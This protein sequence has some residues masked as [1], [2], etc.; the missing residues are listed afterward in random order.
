MASSWIIVNE[1]G[2]RKAVDLRTRTRK[3]VTAAVNRAKKSGRNVIAAYL[4]KPC[5][6]A[7]CPKVCILRPSAAYE[8]ECLPPRV[9]HS[10]G[11][12]RC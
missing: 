10:T 5:A 11:N 1:D 6:I 3:G 12:W 7:L 9:S 8:R 2:Q 4:G